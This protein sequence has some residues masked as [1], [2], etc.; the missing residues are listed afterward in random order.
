[1][2]V[3]FIFI[4][5][6]LLVSTATASYDIAEFL[7]YR[8]ATDIH[9]NGYVWDARY[10]GCQ[11]QF[12]DQGDRIVVD[13]NGSYYRTIDGS[14]ITGISVLLMEIDSMQWKEEHETQIQKDVPWWQWW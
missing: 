14:V 12:A 8:G 9:T 7:K 6:V 1:M 13:L 2:R 4:L 11:I 10:Q 5:A 3:V